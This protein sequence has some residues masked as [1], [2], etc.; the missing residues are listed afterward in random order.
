MHDKNRRS[1]INCTVSNMVHNDINVS[2]ELYIFV[3]RTVKTYSNNC[4]SGIGNNN[5]QKL[6]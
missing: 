6:R 2:V 1:F 5:K 4:H 3:N